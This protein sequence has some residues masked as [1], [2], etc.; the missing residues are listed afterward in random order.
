M[1]AVCRAG[2]LT[3]KDKHTSSNFR[4]KALKPVRANCKEGIWKAKK[5]KTG[6]KKKKSRFNYPLILPPTQH[7]AAEVDAITMTAQLLL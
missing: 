3:T 2:L 5:I 4:E 1:T 6:K 7:T